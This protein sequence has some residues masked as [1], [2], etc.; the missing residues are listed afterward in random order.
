MINVVSDN[1]VSECNNSIVI[2]TD[3]YDDGIVKPYPPSGMWYLM[4]KLFIFGIEYIIDNA[5]YDYLWCLLWLFF[6]RII[7]FDANYD[8]FGND[9]WWYLSF[10]LSMWCIFLPLTSLGTYI[11]NIKPMVLSGKK[12]NRLKV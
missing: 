6:T 12:V 9:L 3:E 2:D 5:D 11:I 4:Q 8:Y 10:F 7:F 1:S